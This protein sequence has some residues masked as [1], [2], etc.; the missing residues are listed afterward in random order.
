M[1]AHLSWI[2]LAVATT[3][4]GKLLVPAQ[5]WQTVDDFA[6]AGSN[7][8]A[9][10]VAV[11]AAGGIYVVGT[12]SGHGIVRY[13]ADGG[14]SWITRD[15]FVY[16]SQANNL[17]NAIAIDHQGALYVG[18]AGGPH[19]IVRRST[20]QGLTWQTV[21]DFYKP[22]INP[23]DPGTNGVVYS[24]SSDAEGRVYGTGL[25][26]IPGPTY[27]RWWVRGSGIGGTNW[28][29]RL[30]IFSGYAG[31]SQLTCAGEDVYVEGKVSD[32]IVTT[33]LI[34]RS[35]DYGATWTTNFQATNEAYAIT[36]DSAANLYAA[37]NKWNSTNGWPTTTDWRV[38][39]A[40]PGGTNW[41]TL[42]AVS[43]N[44]SA[45]G[46]MAPSP[47]SIAI[48]AAGNICVAGRVQNTWIIYD[49]YWT[50]YAGNETWFTRQFSA[51]SG[52]W[53]TTD[54]F[55]YYPT[56]SPNWTNMHSVSLG[57][58]IAPDGSTFVVGYGTSES[59]QRRWVVRKRAASTDAPRLQIAVAGQSVVVSWPAACTNSIL[60]WTDPTGANQLWQNFTGTV[61]VV[62]GRNTATV[63]LSS[64]V[65]SFRLKSTTA[66]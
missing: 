61:R 34:L 1:S 42:D 57:T 2:P 6:L 9:H 21:D 58:A 25:L 32:S 65:R 19:W 60:E 35:S 52:Q 26:H 36:S 16:P 44:D 8:E 27:N 59:G 39:K 17:F 3:L 28:D 41:S 46:G 49:G 4:V 23:G 18:G 53:S 38:R 63:E 24:L 10:G 54:L 55:S 56:N 11:D 12:A 47:S 15:D 13:S 45:D 48:D 22:F 64:G 31:V 5:D 51:A 43:Y 29:T 20:D 40:A 62:N 37:G 7:A 66:H 14:S 33:G 30:V 50:T